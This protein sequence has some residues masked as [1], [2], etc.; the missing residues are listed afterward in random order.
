MTIDDAL[1]RIRPSL[2]LEAD[3]E[4]AVVE[5]LRSH[6]E[7]AVADA[8]A[9]GVDEQQ[10][11]RLALAAFGLEETA[12]EL[13]A[14]HAGR[15]TLDG[16]ALAAVPVIGA[17]VL[18]WL[19]FAPDGSANA[20]PALLTGPAL[21]TIAAVAV[22]LPVVRFPRRRLALALWGFFWGLSIVTVVWPTARW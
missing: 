4:Q 9:R 12:T 18:R 14:T 8:A 2:G 16:I 11:I 7:E 10:A 15:A 19:L 17:L 1:D 5:E 22:L 20:W 13:R 21:V 6:L 3:A